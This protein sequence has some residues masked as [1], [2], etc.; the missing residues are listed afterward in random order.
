MLRLIWSGNGATLLRHGIVYILAQNLKRVIVHAYY[1]DMYCLSTRSE[2]GTELPQ[3]D[4][5]QEALR[6][7]LQRRVEI[8]KKRLEET[9]EKHTKQLA[10]GTYGVHVLGST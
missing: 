10:E 2:L 7:L 8:L 6:L 4:S 5:K 3:A 9:E 1:D